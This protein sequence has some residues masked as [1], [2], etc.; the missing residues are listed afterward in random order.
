MSTIV[1]TLVALSYLSLLV[2][3]VGMLLI[4]MVNDD[5]YEY[6]GGLI[7]RTMNSFFTDGKDFF[8]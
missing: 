3:H 7:M 1:H 8:M 5:E 2:V 6:N 4:T